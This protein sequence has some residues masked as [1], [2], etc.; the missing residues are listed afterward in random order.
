M[1][2]RFSEATARVKAADPAGAPFSA[3]PEPSAGHLGRLGDLT[4]HLARSDEDVR[5]AQELRYRV[6]FEE[7]S[8]RPNPISRAARR[9][10]DGYDPL[11]DHLLVADDEG[12]IVATSRLLRQEIAEANGGFYTASEFDIRPL[13]AARPGL[14]FLELGRSCVLKPYRTTRTAE[15]LWHGIWAYVLR[16]RIDVMIGCASLEG[17]DPDALALPLSFLHHAARAPEDWHASAHEHLRVR[18]DRM[19]AEAIDARAALRSLPPLLRGYLRLG[20][21]VGDGAVVDESFGT[22]DVL[23]IL[24]V[25]AINPRYVRYYGADAGRRAG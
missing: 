18:M 21:F 24:P 17:T 4:V 7:G 13:L 10:V 14:R 16:H 9:D 25:A 2:G 6:F 3:Q 20:A 23:V 5:R 11:C 12:R 19:P 8:A 15:L 1:M 22:T